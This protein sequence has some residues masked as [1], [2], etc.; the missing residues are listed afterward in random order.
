[1]LLARIVECDYQIIAGRELRNRFWVECLNSC[2]VLIRLPAAYGLNPV[3]LLDA[4]DKL[5]IWKRGDKRAPHKPL[6]LLY[7]LAKQVKDPDAEFEFSR[8]EDDIRKLLNEFYKPL[9]GRGHNVNDPFWRLQKDGI[10][11][12]RQDGEIRLDSSGSAS[13]VDLREHN[14]TGSF[15]PEIAKEIEDDPEVVRQAAWKLLDQNF[16]E[17]LHQNILE[18]VGL[19]YKTLSSEKPLVKKTRRDPKFRE[20]VLHAYGYSCAV[21]GFGLRMKTMPVALEAAHIKWH[22]YG[23]PDTENNGLALCATH[24]KLLDSGVLALSEDYRIIL[25]EWIYEPDDENSFIREHLKREI[26]LPRNSRHSPSVDYI[27]WHREEVFK[28]PPIEESV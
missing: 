15:L 9:P 16:A 21:C 22:Q 19:D 4:I 2:S 11:Q 25:S 3:K 18:H 14:A 26:R 24:H 20:N 6:L 23:G 1:M 8:I 13:I 17:S 7:A 10:W 27:R 5:S 28:E 12:V